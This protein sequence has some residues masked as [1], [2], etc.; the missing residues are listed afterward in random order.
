MD[1][2]ILHSDMNSFYASVEI[3][4]NPEL[5]NKP[6]AV[7]GSTEERHGIILTKNQ[8]AKKYGIKTGMVNWEAKLLCPDLVIITPHYEQYIKYSKMAREIYSR[9]TDKIEP[10][11]MDEC[12]LDMTESTELFG[13]G[14]DIANNIRK[15]IKSE[16]GLTVSIGVS[17]NKIFAKLGSDMKKPDAITVINRENY[18]DK[19]WNLPVED[20][21][22][23][24]P[25]TKRKLN[26]IGVQTIGN[27]AKFPV[28]ILKDKLG[29]NGIMLSAY[30]NGADTS[31]VMP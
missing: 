7:G 4:L 6:V 31:P 15:T 19:V 5:R 25:A 2:V 29:K 8:I 24:G 12:W 23:V 9:Y 20:L 16:L 11:G 3:M 28:N 18:K 10:F 30:A 26:S 27:L 22:Y 13:N 17:F 1:R 14:F 21:F